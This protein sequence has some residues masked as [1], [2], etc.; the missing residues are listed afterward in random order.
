MLD[1]AIEA[2]ATTLNIPDTVG[3]TTPD[4]FGA[5]IAGI[6]EQRARHRRRRSSRC[7]ATTTWGWPRPTR[8]AGIQAGAR[9][10]E[11]TINGIGERAGNTSL[12]EVVM[13]LHTR[14]RDASA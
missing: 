8:L 13:A 9:Q 1:D 2:G 6:V 11:V 12:E 7:T 4:E 10:V 5:L 3:Y 14:R